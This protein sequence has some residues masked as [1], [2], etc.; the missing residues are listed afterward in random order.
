MAVDRQNVL[1]AG[2]RRLVVD[3]ERMLRARFPACGLLVFDAH[4]AL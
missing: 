1:V 3:R 2:P 4:V